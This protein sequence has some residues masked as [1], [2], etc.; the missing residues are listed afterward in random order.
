MAALGTVE[1]WDMFHQREQ[2]E[3]YLPL[4]IVVREVLGFIE[5]MKQTQTAGM[6]STR[7]GVASAYPRILHP[8]CGTSTLGVV[9]HRDHGCS[10]VN[11][12]FSKS[13]VDSMRA[14]YQGC[15]FVC[16]DARRTGFADD[17]F[18]LA[19][20]KGLFDSATAGT[21]G[22]AAKAK[23][24]LGEAAR[25]LSP[26]GKYMMF[27]VFCSDGLGHKDMA[28]MLAHPAFR[29]G[30]ETRVLD[31]PPLEYPDQTSS[32]LYI[33]TKAEAEDEDD[34]NSASRDGAPVSF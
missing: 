4:P 15:E 13:V 3:W 14:R 25:V 26:G 32:Y 11:A 29:G 23:E 21:E 22:R 33:L 18:D 2:T 24:L 1:F 9:L 17:S 16:S 6:R 20:D 12:D 30:L 8:G 27:S 34:V 7:E 19:V 31:M 5:E 28:G 10:V